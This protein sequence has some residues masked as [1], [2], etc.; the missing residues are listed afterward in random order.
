MDVAAYDAVV[1]SEVARKDVTLASFTA[2]SFLVSGSFVSVEEG[3]FC[4]ESSLYMSYKLS[5]EYE[6]ASD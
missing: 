1:A 6:S 5:S 4:A 2:R 3:S